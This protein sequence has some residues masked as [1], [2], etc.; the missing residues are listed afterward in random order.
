[1]ASLG[2]QMRRFAQEPA[3][4]A[5]P[6]AS[7]RGP[8]EH[9]P[10]QPAVG[11]ML[12]GMH[13]KISP[14]SPDVTAPAVLPTRDA[15]RLFSFIFPGFRPLFYTDGKA[16]PRLTEYTDNSGVSAMAILSVEENG[17]LLNAPYHPDLSSLVRPLNGRF[18]GKGIGWAF[19]PE[20][21]Q[22]LRTI[23]FRL[24]G[25]DGRPET[26]ADR[27]ALRIEARDR[28]VCNSP[29]K[30]F[31]ADLWLCGRQIAARPPGTRCA[32][33][34]KGVKFLRGRP[35]L[36]VDTLSHS[37]FLEPGTAFLLRDVPRST[38]PRFEE[39][40]IDHGSYELA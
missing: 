7:G 33:P 8:M 10:N 15:Y 32:R 20:H 3:R 26:M 27:V 36:T 35:H 30:T 11:L 9:G 12:S 4:G 1:M 39:A 21:E 38:L 22:A 14:F 40:L 28:Y 18:R 19:A 24:W 25:V 29:W 13:G 34:G 2:I 37:I 5:D 23:C 16:L 17:L 31:N 6:C